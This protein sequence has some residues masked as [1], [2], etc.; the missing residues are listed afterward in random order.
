M[1]A[2]RTYFTAVAVT[3]DMGLPS[4]SEYWNELEPAAVILVGFLLF[5]FPEPATSALGAGLMLLGASWW[6][7]EWGR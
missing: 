2:G 3:G 5:V 1:S 4:Y 6:F 7:Y